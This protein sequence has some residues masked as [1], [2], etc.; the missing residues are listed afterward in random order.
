MPIAEGETNEFIRAERVEKF[1]VLTLWPHHGPDVVSHRLA[2]ENPKSQKNT[3]SSNACLLGSNHRNPKLSV[4]EVD[5]SSGLV[6]AHLCIHTLYSLWWFHNPTKQRNTCCLH[7]CQVSLVWV[8][9]SLPCTSDWAFLPTVRALCHMPFPT[10][11]FS[12]LSLTSASP[13]FQ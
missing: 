7:R 12:L 8:H 1:T 4:A 5:D 3:E 2:C 6:F 10:E 13:L 11:L 9:L